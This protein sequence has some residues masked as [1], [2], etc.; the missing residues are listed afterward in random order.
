VALALLA[1]PLALAVAALLSGSVLLKVAEPVAC[2][3][4]L[5][6]PV[7]LGRA[8]T[9]G[10]WVAAAFMASAAGDYLLA[11][12]G[13]RA[14][15]FAWGIGAF[16]AAHAGYLVFSLLEGSMK[17]L[18]LTMLLAIFLPYYFG[19]LR[20]SIDSRLLSGAS[21]VYLVLSCVTLAAALGTRLAPPSSALFAAGI[22]LIL[23]SDLIISFVEFLRW[24]EVGWL[25][26]PTYYLAHLAIVLSFLVR[27][28]PGA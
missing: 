12:K 6:V 17:W 3:L 4:L 24:K 22:A 23:V 7:F 9:T 13:T 26:L 28:V 21:L 5:L 14:G 19:T 16:L 15:R 18:S 27:L 1:I 2:A 11:T 8:G 20:R 25:I 10:L